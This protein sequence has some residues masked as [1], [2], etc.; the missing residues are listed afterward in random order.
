MVAR[1]STAAAI[2]ANAIADRGKGSLGGSPF[3]ICIVLA[4][5]LFRTALVARMRSKFT[6]LH[7]RTA[8]TGM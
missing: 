3:L 5:F 2:T 7:N 8:Y 1:I 6:A 4:D